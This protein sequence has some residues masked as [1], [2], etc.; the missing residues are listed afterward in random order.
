VEVEEGA[1]ERR[2][3]RGG[4]AEVRQR[5]GGLGEDGIGDGLGHVGDEALGI[6]GA[7][8]G[9]VEAELAGEAEDDGGGDRAV[10]VLHLVQVG[11]ADAELGREV[12]L[13]QA[14]AGA[15]LAQL[16]AG[17]EFLGGHGRLPWF[18]EL[19]IRVCKTGEA[20]AIVR[21]VRVLAIGGRCPRA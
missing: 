2:R 11:E 21:A 10:V 5:R 12:L 20:G 9:H 14:D 18:A 7:E 15:H 13:R 8:L 4:E 1:R 19:R 6:A 16:G 3:V 17:I